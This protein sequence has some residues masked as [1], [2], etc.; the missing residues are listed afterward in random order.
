MI[1][2]LPDNNKRLMEGATRLLKVASFTTDATLD[3]LV[4]ASRA[5]ASSAV[6]RHGVWLRA[7]PADLRAKNIV[8]AYPFQGEKLFGESLDRILVEIRDKKKV[9]PRII[10]QSNR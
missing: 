7:W 5:F 3:V 10:R 8:S 6:A 2:L 1:Q 9:M 4:F